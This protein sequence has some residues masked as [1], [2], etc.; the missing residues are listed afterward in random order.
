MPFNSDTCKFYR[1]L[2]PEKICD[3]EC[4]PSIEYT[5]L[6]GLCSTIL[7]KPYCPNQPY[8][9]NNKFP[10]CATATATCG[11]KFYLA[12]DGATYACPDPGILVCPNSYKV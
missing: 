3:I 1:E 4:N 5:H 7:I 9:V 11:G 12:V 6:N 10:T 8:K 2:T